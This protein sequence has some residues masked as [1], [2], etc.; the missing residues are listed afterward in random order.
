M[1]QNLF[2]ENNIKLM[3]I[4]LKKKNGRVIRMNDS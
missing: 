3:K 4:I 2:N 1:K